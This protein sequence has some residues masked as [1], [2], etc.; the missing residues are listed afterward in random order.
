MAGVVQRIRV[1]GRHTRGRASIGRWS[2]VAPFAPVVAFVLAFALV[3][4]VLLFLTSWVDV[5]GW[6]GFVS[7]VTNPLAVT[8]FQNSLEQGSLSAA[9]GVALGYPFG[10]LL[11]RYTWRGR[12]FIQAILVVPFILPA[13]V[14]VLGVRDLLTWGMATGIPGFGGSAPVVGVGAIVAVNV[15]YNAPI[16]AL[17]TAVGVESASVEL[18]E[19]VATLGGGPG[20]SYRSVW[21]PGSWVGAAAGG[22]LTFV[23]S[24]LAFAAPLLLCGAS[25]YTAEVWVWAL[26]E[27]LASPAAAGALAFALLLLMVAPTVVYVVLWSRLRSIRASH[28]RPVRPIPW[29]RP[30]GW[31]L[32][33]ASA[34]F[35]VSVLALLGTVIWVSIAPTAIS[36]EWGYGWTMLFGAEVSDA[37]GISTVGALA[38]SLLFGA[39]AAGIALFFGLLVGFGRGVT[40]R[41]IRGLQVLLLTPLVISPVVLAFAL[42]SFWRPVLG[43]ESSIWLLI[44]ISQAT[45]AFPFALQSLNVALARVPF[46]FRESAQTL[47]ASP[48]TAYADTELPQVRSGIITAGLF[49]FALGL[50]EFTATFFLAI[51]RFTTLPVEVFRLEELRLDAAA[52]ALAGFL[53]VV[54]LLVFVG[55]AWGGRRFEL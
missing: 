14:M 16:V 7:V 18:E 10:I 53:V 28:A 47:G 49:A 9:A 6:T 12:S 11:G 45:L 32:V 42:A 5:D 22:L 2:A 25:C 54:S 41:R 44:V 46:A 51:P 30:S 29:N 43:G 21:G 33:A 17:L 31:V 15:L 19:T 52:N 37:L 35:F 40:G 24:A 55:V 39:M 27:E 4:V 3:P 23:F 13:I 26:A 50:G 8:A 48:W 1:T 38:N 34:V 36:P 20:R